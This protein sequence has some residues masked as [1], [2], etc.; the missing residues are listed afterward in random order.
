MWNNWTIHV[1]SIFP[2]KTSPDFDSSEAR[3]KSSGS[4]VSWRIP[5]RTGGWSWDIIRSTPQA[6]WDAMR[7]GMG[8]PWWRWA[9]YG[10]VKSKMLGLRGK[11][12][13]KD[14]INAQKGD[15]VWGLL[16][17]TG[18]LTYESSR[19]GILYKLIYCFKW[20]CIYIHTYVYTYMFFKIWGKYLFSSFIEQS[21]M[22]FARAHVP[23]S[24]YVRMS[25]EIS[26]FRL[27]VILLMLQCGSP[28]PVMWTL[29]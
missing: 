26:E 15:I 14:R 12:W 9:K 11:R 22:K 8:S 3:S 29:V 2:Q 25:E 20:I 6:G 18:D 21:W 5:K 19:M 4:S 16:W 13:V 24:I 17:Y 23:G 28:R 1:I 7:L 10:Y 27:H